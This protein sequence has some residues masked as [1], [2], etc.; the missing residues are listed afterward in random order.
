MVATAV[1]L[2]QWTRI[3]ITPHPGPPP[4]GGREMLGKLICCRAPAMIANRVKTTLFAF[5]AVRWPGGIAA[6]A[7]AQRQL[8]PPLTSSPLAGRIEEGGW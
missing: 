2:V 5:G 8:P 4:Q 6:N 7:V 1:L 3:D